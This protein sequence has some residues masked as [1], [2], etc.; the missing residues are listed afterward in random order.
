MN[1]QRNEHPLRPP[2]YNSMAAYSTEK[3]LIP[4]GGVSAN[5]ESASAGSGVVS[6]TRHKTA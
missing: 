4:H 3:L 5:G 2:G 6:L 1:A